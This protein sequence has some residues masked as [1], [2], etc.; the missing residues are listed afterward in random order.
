MATWI[1]IPLLGSIVLVQSFGELQLINRSPDIERTL[2][3]ARGVL[4]RW[5]RRALEDDLAF[6]GVPLHVFRARGD[7][8]RADAQER[9]TAQLTAEPL[10]ARI[11]SDD[12]AA[13]VAYV[14]GAGS[15]R[16]AGLAVQQIIGRCFQPSYRAGAS[17]YQAGRTLDAWP[18]QPWNA[19]LGPVSGRL[20]RAKGRVAQAAGG[21]AHAV[22]GTSIA[23]QNV[24]RSLQHLRRRYAD[25]AHA[26]VSHRDLAAPAV[27]VRTAVR[28]TALP[29]LNR[30]VPE[31]TLFLIRLD[32]LHGELDDPR[33]VFLEGEWSRCPAHA[34]VP[35]L[36]QLVWQHALTSDA[37][38]TSAA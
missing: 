34:F 22:H 23:M 26:R 20:S 37:R 27:V 24:V 32:R 2:R 10:A 12:L 17:T 9:L 35:A 28:A 18:R 38:R 15:E 36:L 19:L 4:G 30:V 5:L 8:D 16:A 11:A 29:F 6:A 21:D 13:L 33:L 7:Q 25:G 1:R 31:G 14:R 3:P